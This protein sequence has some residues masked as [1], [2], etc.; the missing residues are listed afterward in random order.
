MKRRRFIFYALLFLAGCQSAHQRVG[1]TYAK[2]DK[3]RFAV[4]DAQGLEELERDY[5]IFKNTLEELLSIPIEFFPVED[6]FM[7]TSA[8]QSAQVDL[9]WAGPSEYVVIAAR[10]D[11]IPLVSIARPEYY[12]TIAVRADSGIQSLADLKGKT[13]DIRKRGS[14]ASHLGAIALLTAAGL[15]PQTDVNTIASKAF[16][17]RPLKTGAADAWSRTSYR[18]T[19]ALEQ[20]G[21]TASDYP[22][23][24]E[25][26]PLPGD[27]LLASSHLDSALVAQLQMQILAGQ[28]QLIQAILA[29]DTL[30]FRFQG[31]Y[32]APAN[33]ADYDI[34][35]DAYRA[36]GQGDFIM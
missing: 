3:L 27:I 30:A 35:R 36:I 25:G 5:D 32:F 17:L 19:Q 21:A 1:R 22:L 10:T 14:T 9:V 11:A 18:Y 6:Y 20:E 34:I 31:T 29:V 4:T 16:S 13:I 33:D 12:T 24:A 28:E 26:K 2:P 8:L 7:A 23:I 15:D